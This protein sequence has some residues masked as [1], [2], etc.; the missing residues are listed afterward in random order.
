MTSRQSEF[1]REGRPVRDCLCSGVFWEG[2]VEWK[3][4][5]IE[6]EGKGG[7]IWGGKET[8]DGKNQGGEVERGHDAAIGLRLEV[9]SQLWYTRTISKNSAIS[10]RWY[11]TYVIRVRI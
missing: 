3:G 6:R 8:G 9:G 1:E 4:C 11:R 2:K 5:G 10:A 7:G